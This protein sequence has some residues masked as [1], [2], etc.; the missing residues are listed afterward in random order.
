MQ[1]LV[2]G[3]SLRTSSSRVSSLGFTLTQAPGGCP[4]VTLPNLRLLVLEQEAP[5]A[6]G[7]LLHSSQ[8]LPSSLDGL[9]CSSLPVKGGGGG[10]W[11]Q[12]TPHPNGVTRCDHLVVRSPDWARTS[13]ALEKLGFKEALV[14]TDVYPGTRLSFW[15]V[16]GQGKG[17]TLELV[18]P[19]VTKEGQGGPASLWGATWL[20][21]GGLEEVAGALGPGLELGASKSAVQGQGRKIATLKGP[22]AHKLGLAMAFITP[23]TI[24][25]N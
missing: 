24:T 13:G 7:L 5:G 6:P 21:G 20:A 9:P 16:G 11:G 8:P 25:R 1:S 2:T 10:G 18:A 15:R 23:K 4:T 3:L 19:L 17:L 22:E 14:K 12:S